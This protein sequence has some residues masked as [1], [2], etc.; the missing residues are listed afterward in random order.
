MK[1]YLFPILA[2]L[3]LL[4]S[5]GGGG[6]NP[7]E[8]GVART[9]V[10]GFSYKLE[11][12]FIVVFENTSKNATSYSWDFGD[13]TNSS[14]KNPIHQYPGKGVYKVT[15]T[16]KNH[17]KTNVYT[18]NVT[19]TA[20]TKCYVHRIEYENIPNNNEYYSV[21]CTD[22]YLIFETLYWH[23][24]PVLLSSAN[25]PYEYI[26]RTQQQVNFSLKNFVIRLYKH[27]SPSASGSEIKHWILDTEDIKNTYPNGYVLKGDNIKLNINFVWN[28]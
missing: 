16:A 3:A 1:T 13:G 8:I 14:D 20:P 27:S 25:L 23:T 15:L 19:I 21:R 5:C 9:P 28:D 6:Y 11:H 18:K 26:L 2:V 24:S 7:P 17:D 4:V 22:N 10:A 12:P